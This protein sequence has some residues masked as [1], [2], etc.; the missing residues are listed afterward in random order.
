MT[1][2]VLIVVGLALGGLVIT[3][4]YLVGTALAAGTVAAPTITSSPANPTTSSTATFTFSDTKSGATFKCSLDGSAFA[5]CTSGISYSGLTQASHTF[6]VEALSGANTSAVT[7]YTWSIVPP[8]PTINSSPSNPTTSTTA[9]FTFSDT[10]A[11]VGFECSL[12]GGAFASCASGNT[13]SGLSGGSQTFEVEAV[14]GSNPASS[15]ASYSWTI[16]TP[17]PTITSQPA[18]PTSST[19]AS[20][21]YTDAQAGAAF[22]C[23]LNGGS[24]STCSSSGDSFTGLTQGTQTFSVEAQLGSGPL[25]SPATYSWQI[26]TSAPSISVTF[27]A[28]SAD[29]NQTGW[30]AGCSPVGVCGTASDPA[31]VTQVSVGIL[32][33]SSGEYWN[34]SSFS[35]SSQ[36]FNT[37]TGTTSWNYSFAR[38][39]DGVYTLYV[40]A[41]DSLGNTTTTANLTTVTFTIDTVPPAAPSIVSDPANPTTATSATFVFTDSSYPDVTYFCAMDSSPAVNCSG[42]PDHGSK[43]ADDNEWQYQNLTTGSHCFAIYAVDEASNV[44]P[45]TTYCWSIISTPATIAVSSGSGQSAPVTTAFGS[46]LVAEVTDGQG[47][48]VS[49]V[50]VTFAAPTSGASGTFATCAGG[51]PTTAQC[52]ITTG[53][54]GLATSSAFTA[55]TTTGSYT[56]TATASG[57]AS[58]AD[59]SL[60]NT[61]GPAATIAVSSGSGQSATVHIAFASPLVAKV[62]DAYGNLVSGATVTFTTPASGASGTFAGSVNTAVT[63]ANGLATSTTF[64]ANTTAGGYNVGASATGTG[65]VNFAETNTAGTASSISVS[66]G[67]GQSA[68]VHTAFASPLVALVTDTYGN[69]VSGATVTFTAPGTGASGTFAGSVNTAVTNASGLATS[70]TFTANTTAGSYNVGASATGTGSVNFAETNAAAAANNIAVS[71]GAGQSAAVGTAFTAPLVAVVT[72]NYGNPVSG[73]TVTFAAPGSGASGTF[74]GSVNTAV[75]NTNG[76]A[77]STTF[78]ANTKVGGYNVTASASGAGSVKFAETNTAGTAATVVV[79]SGSNQSATVDTAFASPLVAKVTDASGNVVSGA[80]VTFTA[81]G[82]GASGTFDG[83]VNTAVTNANGLATSTTFTANSTAGSYAVSATSGTGAVNFTLTNTAGAAAAIAISSGSGQTAAVHTAFA[84]PLVAEV[85]DSFGN[86]VSGVSVTFTPPGSGASG[87]FAGSGS[88]TTNAS[89]LATS[90]TFTANTTAGSYNVSVSASGAGS[91][92]FPETNAPGAATQLVFVTQPSSGQKVTAGAATP[93]TVNI[94]DTYGNAETGDNSSQVTL[95]LT[96][97][98][99]A[100]TLTCTNSGGSGPVTVAG[101]VANFSCSL[102]KAGTGYTLA[103]TSNPTHGT[104]TTNAFAIVAGSASQLVFTTQ[105]PASTVASSTFTTAVSIEDID[106][107]VVTSDTNTVALA[108]STNPCSGTLA[109]TTSEAA[110]AGVATFSGLQ[111]TTACSGYVLQAADAADGPLLTNSNAFAVTPASVSKLVFTTEPPTSTPSTSTFGVAATIED[112]YGNTETGD[113]HAVVLSLTTNPCSGTLGGTTSEAAVAGVATF[114]GL[115]ITTA[116]SGYVL[117]AADAADGPI[118]ATSTPFAITGA[119]AASITESSG[120]PQF[121]TVSTAFGSPLVAKVTDAQSNPVAGVTV[122]FSAPSS[123]AS[124]TFGSCSSGNPQSYSCVVTTNGS[125]LATASTFTANSTAGAY[126]VSASAPGVGTPATFSLTNSA[127]FTISGNVSTPLYPG[128]GQSVNLTI[129]NPNPTPITIAAGA[130]EITISDSRPGCPASSNFTMSQGLTTAV[131]VPGGSTQSLSQLGV[132]QA[133]WPVV[134]MVDTHTNQ[135]ACEG[136][137]LTLNYAGSASG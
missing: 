34:G 101:G 46:P 105:P 28:A 97:N 81:P 88:V 74:A 124:G 1:R 22:K 111:I 12:N 129:T 47:N 85:T 58:P 18:N 38:P 110:T 132:P 43:S 70:K 19:T 98:P 29:Y 2:R 73:A 55:N 133:D 59:F 83:S 76:L 114:S 11:G 87:T 130:V 79:S 57:V 123:G 17:T 24:Y 67:S 119:A 113:T 7:S 9:T 99:G 86:S 3:T 49:G 117:Q 13:Y 30:S 39:V 45:T 103:A 25:S 104:A 26:D 68:T 61:A 72:D 40:K 21:T 8:T 66:S 15:A 62:T 75:T 90:K 127:N 14:V 54:N 128:T 16:T 63:T 122:T 93:F 6:E 134:T 118:T 109:G 108:L 44:G 51:N 60:T 82:S 52:V 102:N 32:Q 125:G 91:V 27:P 84:S 23:S 56:V 100:S 126:S 121:T 77:T 71:S 115:Q 107:N 5:A 41:T 4:G 10:Q 78:T 37:A 69:P 120:S 42:D 95:A 106:G 64:T 89:G 94:E 135:D 131:T 65:S 53:A 20:F 116:C 31:G 50:P 80:T 92:N 36:V 33:K 35:S 137:T 112:I 48:P 96:T 136:A